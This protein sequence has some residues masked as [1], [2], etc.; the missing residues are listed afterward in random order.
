MDEEINGEE[1]ATVYT[2]FSKSLWKTEIEGKCTR[3]KLY[4]N[5][6]GP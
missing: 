4:K 2:T 1:R 6:L 3:F 5:K